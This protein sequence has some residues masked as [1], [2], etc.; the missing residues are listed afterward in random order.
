MQSLLEEPG[1]EAAGEQAENSNEPT[2]P[3]KKKKKK[4]RSSLFSHQN[5]LKASAS[6]QAAQMQ[7]LPKVD[8]CGWV[9]NDARNPKQGGKHSAVAELEKWRAAG[10]HSKESLVLEEPTSIDLIWEKF[11]I[12]H[13]HKLAADKLSEQDIERGVERGCG[14]LDDLTRLIELT[15]SRCGNSLARSYV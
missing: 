15:L 2:A 13:Y 5:K 12:G 9:R 8:S 10:A 7:Q 3:T 4:A 11:T 1:D 14:L 6:R